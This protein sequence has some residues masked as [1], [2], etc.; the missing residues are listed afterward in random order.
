MQRKT[1][2]LKYRIKTWGR[3]K[4]LLCQAWPVPVVA[5][6]NPQQPLEGRVC[7]PVLPAWEWVQW[8]GAEVL[9]PPPGTPELPEACS[10]LAPQPTSGYKERPL[11]CRARWREGSGLYRGWL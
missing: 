6:Q 3:R 7:P 4:Q 2:G 1:L 8:A 5:P 11:H 10:Q 9:V